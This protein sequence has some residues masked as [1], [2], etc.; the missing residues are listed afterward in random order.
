MFKKFVFDPGMWKLEAEAVE[1]ANFCGNRSWKRY[2][3]TAS[4]LTIHIERQNLNIIWCNFLKIMRRNV[5]VFDR[6]SFAKKRF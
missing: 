3:G 5:N 4:T 6:S 2:N 1:A